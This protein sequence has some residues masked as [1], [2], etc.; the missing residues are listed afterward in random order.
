MQENF[1]KINELLYRINPKDRFLYFFTIFRDLN[2]EGTDLWELKR[3]I[4]SITD[5]NLL[6]I[7]DGLNNNP[8]LSQ[9]NEPLSYED[10]D[11]LII[12]IT[13][14]LLDIST[15]KY[16]N[17]ISI[18]KSV[19]NMNN[20]ISSIERYYQTMESLNK[21]PTWT[22]EDI[23]HL[24]RDVLEFLCK[25]EVEDMIITQSYTLYDDAVDDIERDHAYWALLDMVDNVVKLNADIIRNTS[26]F[27]VNEGLALSEELFIA[28][29]CDIFEAALVDSVKNVDTLYDQKFYTV[30]GE[31]FRL[32][33][34]EYYIEDKTPYYQD[35]V[36]GVLKDGNI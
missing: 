21:K 33:E 28:E 25:E 11:Q 32:F 36:E 6:M 12:L 2:K 19:F 5:D 4:S 1:K 35:L 18:F 15:N 16:R 20:L 7:I 17:I 3:L 34:N 30:L 31:I 23:Y 24:L 8:L 13:S 26:F 22:M 29:I 27:Y 14:T 10:I 9:Y